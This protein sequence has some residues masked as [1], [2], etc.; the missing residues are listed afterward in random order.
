VFLQRQFVVP[1]RQIQRGDAI[2]ATA[3]ESNPAML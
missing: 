2:E 1:A 3:V